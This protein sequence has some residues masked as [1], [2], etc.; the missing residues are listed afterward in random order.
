MSFELVAITEHVHAFAVWD[1]SWK[2]FNNCYL[3]LRKDQVL[4]VDCGKEMHA[5]HLVEALNRL[6]RR[7]EEV[8][9]V[10]ATHG[11]KDHV[12]AIGQFPNA[13]A[14]LHPRDRDLLSPEL[15]ERFSAD[16]PDQG[17]VLDFDTLLLGHHTPGSVALFHRPT[18]TLI[19]GDH[20]CFFG[21]G[22]PPGGL[23]SPAPELRQRAMEFVSG[24]AQ[25]EENRSKYRFDHFM[26]GLRALQQY[27]SVA[28]CSGHGGV[29]TGS[30]PQFIA[31]LISRGEGQ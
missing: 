7:P 23:V 12:G 14:W 22:L 4:L 16:L 6:G 10:I 27:E 25:H 26:Q 31:E 17:S 18:R 9:H 13:R 30:I 1:E 5:E 20:F 8:T 3:F 19:A 29:V 2:S 28:F 15:K 21:E 24:W 11:H